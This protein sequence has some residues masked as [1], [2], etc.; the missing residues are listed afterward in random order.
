[1]VGGVCNRYC[2]V[3]VEVHSECDVQSS[4]CVFFKCSVCVSER[5]PW[6]GLGLFLVQSVSRIVSVENDLIKLIGRSAELAGQDYC[7]LLSQ[8]FCL[9]CLG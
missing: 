7:A 9:F 6:F 2:F 8:Y 4:A 1:M 5:R 3:H